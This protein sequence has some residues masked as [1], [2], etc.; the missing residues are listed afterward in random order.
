MKN[1]RE[2]GIKFIVTGMGLQNLEILVR[3]PNTS[4]SNMPVVDNVQIHS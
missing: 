3:F 4:D 1:Q 2:Y